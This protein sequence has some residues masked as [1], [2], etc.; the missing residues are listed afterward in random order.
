MHMLNVLANVTDQNMASQFLNDVE[1]NKT[2]KIRAQLSET[3]S[4]YYDP[5]S[6]L[7]EAQRAADNYML[8]KQRKPMVIEYYKEKPTS[9]N[10]E[11]FIESVEMYINPQRLNVQYQKIKGK[12]ITRGGIF[13][14]HWG[15]DNP[16][17]SLSGTVGYAGMKGIEQLE[18]IYLNSGALL[19]YGHLD[20]N[21]VNNGA[22]DKYKPID[23]DNISGIISSVIADPSGVAT[24]FALNGVEEAIN[25]A[26]TSTDR[27]QYNIVKQIILNL[28]NVTQQSEYQNAYRTISQE[29]AEEA[30]TMKTPELGVLYR[31][32]QDKINKNKNLSNINP[33]TKILMAFDIAVPYIVPNDKSIWSVI[34]QNELNAIIKSGEYNT[35][36]DNSTLNSLMNNFLGIDSGI[37]TKTYDIINAQA[38][39]L[40]DYIVEINEA[41]DSWK[42]DREESFAGWAD[43]AD[44][45]FDAYRPRLIFIYFEDR[46]YLGHFD[47]FSYSR[48]AENMLIQ[49]EMRFTV[50]RQIIMSRTGQKPSNII[51]PMANYFDTLSKQ[52]PVYKPSWIVPYENDKVKA[53]L[54]VLKRISQITLSNSIFNAHLDKHKDLKQYA[55]NADAIA[56][57]KEE[58]GQLKSLALEWA[59]EYC[60]KTNG[61]INYYK[62]MINATNYNAKQLIEYFSLV[63]KEGVK[64][65]VLKEY[66]RI[67]VVI[68]TEAEKNRLTY[69]RKSQIL[70]WLDQV[71][72]ASTIEIKDEFLINFYQEGLR[73]PPSDTHMA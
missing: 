7:S 65:E 53:Y 49:Y 3:E 38:S 16:I 41:N 59:T 42:V 69:T 61:S 30:G 27:K 1:Y 5:T 25:N 70:S 14:H 67:R 28:K 11:K 72:N 62:T 17:M 13:Y 56:K 8:M 23:L 55:L 32:A 10:A 57:L 12:A 64:E 21:K 68:Q 58:I 44:E 18:R 31:S 35:G 4:R 48:V 63:G 2:R 47:S 39:K 66:T 20:L 15:D 29:I 24:Q 22:P 33:Q 50:V 45:V 9:I 34:D 46:V 52:N 40:N 43:I 37:I 54:G 73:K 36:A 19:K 60:A 6:P 71:Y 51:S 26:K